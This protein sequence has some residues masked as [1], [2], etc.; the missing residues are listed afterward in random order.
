MPLQYSTEKSVN[1]FNARLSTRVNAEIG[2]AAHETAEKQAVMLTG[3]AFLSDHN[4]ERIA[5]EK[6]RPL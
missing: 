2:A 1:S 3:G 6:R 4:K 5:R